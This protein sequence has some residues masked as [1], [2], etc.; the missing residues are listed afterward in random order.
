MKKP[1]AI[2]I[3]KILVTSRWVSE[4][5]MIGFGTYEAKSSM[6]SL[7][8]SVSF[9]PDFQTINKFSVSKI[10]KTNMLLIHSALTKLASTN[11]SKSIQ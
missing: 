2:R 9:S 1:V 10:Y 11:I 4:S 8:H 5:Q 6:V 3:I 7:Q